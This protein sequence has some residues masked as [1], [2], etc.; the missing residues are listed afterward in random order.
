MTNSTTPFRWTWSHGLEVWQSWELLNPNNRALSAYLQTRFNLV[1]KGINCTNICPQSNEW[2]HRGWTTI[3]CGCSEAR[4]CWTE[5]GI[6]HFIDQSVQQTN[7]FNEL[8]LIHCKL[9]LKKKVKRCR[10]QC[11]AFGAAETITCGKILFEAI[12]LPWSSLMNTCHNEEEPNILQQLYQLLLIFPQHHW[13]MNQ[14]QEC[15]KLSNATL[16]Q[17]FSETPANS[18]LD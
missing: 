2:R 16:M 18:V 11:G 4:K 12:A 3:F 15:Q 9:G 17:Q 6:L 7:N 14:N 13:Q 1:Q 10:W 5:A 8:F